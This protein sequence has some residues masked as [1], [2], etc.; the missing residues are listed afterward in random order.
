MLVGLV[1]LDTQEPEAGGSQVQ[2]PVGQQNEF[3]II[4]SQIKLKTQK[5][6]E[7][8]NLPIIPLVRG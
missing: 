3:K 2:E 8:W 1:T 6:L 7:T 5:G 4:L